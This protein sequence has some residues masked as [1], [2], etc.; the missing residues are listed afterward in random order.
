MFVIVF[1]FGDEVA[2]MVPSEESRKRPVI[3][4]GVVSFFDEN[5]DLIPVDGATN[6]P[7]K[8]AVEAVVAVPPVYGY[9]QQ[10][11]WLKR[12][13]EKDVPKGS[14]FWIVDDQFDLP[15]PDFMSAWALD[16]NALGEPVGYGGGTP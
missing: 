10:M 7:M 15:D 13:G 3:H 4:P 12:I 11:E 16:H 2:V 14:P 6:K 1:E 9:E 5:G 8:P